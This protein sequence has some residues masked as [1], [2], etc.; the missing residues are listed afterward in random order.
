M[1]DYLNGTDVPKESCHILLLP[2]GSCC[3]NFSSS[4]INF[5]LNEVSRLLDV[6]IFIERLGRSL[7]PRS[8][9]SVLDPIDSLLVLTSWLMWNIR[10]YLHVA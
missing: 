6:I 3:V 4:I 9:W 2:P 10:L 5:I 1:S 8:S 7:V